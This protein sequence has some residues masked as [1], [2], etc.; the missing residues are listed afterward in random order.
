[1]QKCN[2]KGGAAPWRPIN[3]V[4]NLYTLIFTLTK[5][6]SWS[7]K[8]Y[9][10]TRCVRVWRASRLPCCRNTLKR[11]CIHIHTSTIC[12]G[13][14]NKALVKK[15]KIKRKQPRY[16]YHRQ[17]K[18]MPLSSTVTLLD[19]S[20]SGGFP[21]CCLSW[22]PAPEHSIL[23]WITWISLMFHNEQEHKIKEKCK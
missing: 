7:T 16:W 21:P 10:L 2:E 23:S 6:T 8:W 13:K 11:C 19:E 17:V 4:Q 3:H 22:F 9:C 15:K 20:L 1:M 5:D 18:K 12:Q 14:Y